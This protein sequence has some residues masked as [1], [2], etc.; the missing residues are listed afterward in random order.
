MRR[1]VDEYFGGKLIG[2]GCATWQFIFLRIFLIK[3]FLFLIHFLIYSRMSR[4]NSFVPR[5]SSRL[6]NIQPSGNI[7]RNVPVLNRD[8]TLDDMLRE[9]REVVDTLF[10]GNH[11]P[12]SLGRA[13][14]RRVN[15][16]VELFRLFLIQMI[17]GNEVF[18]SLASVYGRVISRLHLISVNE[19]HARALVVHLESLFH[20]IYRIVMSA[21]SL[22]RRRH[23]HGYDPN[24]LG[25]SLYDDEIAADVAAEEA[26]AAAEAR[27]LDD[28]F[29]RDNAEFFR[30]DND[31]L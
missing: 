16:Q 27:R 8:Q 10:V 11:V 26:A 14:R 28:E 4:S 13:V 2:C 18:S 25:R 15:H 19:P 30:R 9:F 12:M 17:T 7:F 20:E 21:G 3:L 23:A 24:R 22:H 6:P 31:E 29:R 1:I 5:R